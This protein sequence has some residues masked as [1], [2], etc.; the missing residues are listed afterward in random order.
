MILRQLFD[1]ESS[2]YTY[3]IGANGVGAIIDPVLG[4]LERDAKLAGE[5]G[6]K[7][8][9]SLDTHVHAD[10]V[11]AAGTLREQFGVTTIVGKKSSAACGDKKLGDGDKITIGGITL[12]VIE[13]PGHTDDSV[14]YYAASE[15]VLFTGDTLLIRGCGR[16]DFQNG[17]PQDLYHSVKRKLFVLPE[18]TVVCPGHDY[19]GQTRSTIGEEMHFNPRLRTHVTEEQFAEIMNNLNLPDPKLMDVAVP[20]NQNCGI[21]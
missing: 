14:C 20:A 17:S 15:N 19:R 16:T 9:Y 12:S 8:A 6:L 1:K 7:L 2:T 11:T 5:L 10:H 3:L 13:T 4:N 18:E 21:D